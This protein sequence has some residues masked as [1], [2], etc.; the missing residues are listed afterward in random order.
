MWKSLL[1]LGLILAPAYI[2]SQNEQDAIRYGLIKPRGTTRSISMGGA[3]NALGADFSNA[4]GN[5]AGLGLFRKSQTSFTGDLVISP[6]SSNF[7]NQINKDTKTT[8]GIGNAGF[9]Y[10]HRSGNA[11]KTKGWLYSNFYVGYNKINDFNRRLVMSGNNA[12]SSFLEPWLNDINTGNYNSFYQNLA[13]ESELFIQPTVNDLYMAFNTPW[14]GF[15]KT[16]SKHI[17]GKG[18]LGEINFAFAGNLSHKLY[19][20]ASFNVNVLNYKEEGIYNERDINDEV[21]DF[22]N[23]S[24]TETFKTKGTGYN[25]KFGIIYRPVDLV[26]FGLSIH[27]PT[28]FTLTDKFNNSIMATYDNGNTV[29]KNSPDGYYRYRYVSPMK[30]NAS[31]AF[32]VGR[33]LSI[34]TEYEYSPTNGTKFKEFNGQLMP[35]TNVLKNYLQTVHTV[36]LGG[37]YKVGVAGI[38]AGAF[39]G[40]SLMQRQHSNPMDML[41]ISA[42]VGFRLPSG[43]FI[44]LAYQYMQSKSKFWMYDSNLVEP[45]AISQ[46]WHTPS[47]TIGVSF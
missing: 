8:L 1:L 47:L 27:T 12:T 14:P 43:F 17:L 36:R 6:S 5:V 29:I 18:S 44:D 10:S 19:I 26:R 38:R 9:L 4:S 37:E 21:V 11:T 30:V 25:L 34:S 33:K 3:I 35:L 42:G 24:F 32:V 16:Q 22:N 7:A 13:V 39:Y 28:W 40:T 2:F 45:V 20:G 15:N 23:F 41:G 46:Q 31:I